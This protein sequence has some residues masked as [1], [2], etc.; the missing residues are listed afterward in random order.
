M[1]VGYTIACGNILLHQAQSIVLTGI[2]RTDKDLLLTVDTRVAHGAGT[3]IGRQFVHTDAT[4]LTWRRSA[5][6]DLLLTDASV[7]TSRTFARE[8][9][10]R[11]LNALATILT[12]CPSARVTD[13]DIELT[14]NS[15]I[16]RLAGAGVAIVT[17]AAQSTI[18]TW[19]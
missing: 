7:P 2:V 17:V 10:S 3:G 11:T 15:Q 8:L 16:S 6:I 18:L 13:G 9:Q 5:F 19:I 4:V 1:I 12:T 14:V